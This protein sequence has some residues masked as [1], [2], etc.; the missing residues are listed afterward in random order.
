MSST[1]RQFL[2]TAAAFGLTMPFMG[3]ARAAGALKIGLL[4]PASG[5]FYRATLFA[6]NGGFDPDFD[7]AVFY[8]LNV[9]LWKSRV[10][11]KPLPLRITAAPAQGSRGSSWADLREEASRG[12]QDVENMTRGRARRG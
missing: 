6:E 9:R 1:R 10:R 3:R 2:S 7:A 5:T 12:M 4:L 8:E 11:F